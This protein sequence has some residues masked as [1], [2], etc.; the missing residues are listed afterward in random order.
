MQIFA[1]CAASFRESVHRAAGVVPVTCPPYQVD[2]VPPVHLLFERMQAANFLYFKLHGLAGQPYWY[3]DGWMTAIS[4]AQL[5]S[6]D[7]SGAVVF[8]ANCFLADS[9]MLPALLDAGARAVVGGHGENYARSR[10]VDGADL[11]GLWFRRFCQAGLQVRMA[12]A[13]SKVRLKARR[14]T[15]AIRDALAFELWTPAPPGPP[16]GGER[17]AHA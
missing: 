1:F 8:V 9:P 6:L 11:L 12:M 4:A 10:G 17:G 15:K 14:P 5:C 13:L 7:L 16:E 2:G 3:G